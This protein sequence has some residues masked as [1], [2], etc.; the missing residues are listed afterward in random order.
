MRSC[1]CYQDKEVNE[2]ITKNL[3][4]FHGGRQ[5]V[6]ELPT[7]DKDVVVGRHGHHH[8]KPESLS[9][10]GNFQRAGF[11]RNVPRGGGSFSG[12][13]SHTS[14]RGGGGGG[15]STYSGK[16]VQEMLED[17]KSWK[18]RGLIDEDD[19]KTQKTK[20]LTA[21]EHSFAEMA[22]HSS[23]NGKEHRAASGVGFP[24]TTH[25]RTY[26]DPQLIIERRLA[27]E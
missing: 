26:K 16:G 6:G 18:D 20:I 19:Y 2:L 21:A 12:R 17:L 4:G 5:G 7:P 8:H 11:F 23:Q 25:Q 27:R 24:S 14:S 3:D 1:E 15:K 10:Q 13:A 9:S 22:S